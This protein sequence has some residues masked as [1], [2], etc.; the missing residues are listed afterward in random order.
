MATI[1]GRDN[2]RATTNFLMDD[3]TAEIQGNLFLTPNGEWDS[4]IVTVLHTGIDTIKQ[5]YKG[6]IKLD[7]FE[8]IESRYTDKFYTIEFNGYAGIEWAISSAQRGGYRYSLNNRDLGIVVMIGDIHTESKYEGHHL[9][10]ELSPWFILSKSIDVLQSCIDE[11]ASLFIHMF[12]HTGVAIHLCTDVQGWQVPNDLDSRLVTRAQRIQKYSGA[13]ELQYEKHSVATVYGKG[14]TFTFGGAGALQFSV[15]NKSKLIKK[16]QFIE[17]Y[18]HK[19]Y[20][21]KTKPILD[22]QSEFLEEFILFDKKKDVTRLEVRFHH[23]VIEQFARGLSVDL[24]SFKQVSEHLTGL[25]AYAFNNFRLD[26]S[27]TYIDPFWQFMRDDIVFNHDKNSIE[28]RR[29]YK[30]TDFDSPPSDRILKIIQGLL[31]SCYRRLKYDL[32]TAMQGL[33]KSGIWEQLVQLYQNRNDWDIDYTRESAYEDI[34]GDLEIKLFPP[35][36]LLP[37]C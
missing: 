25:W 6:Y 16:N 35:P 37:V 32:D 8:A 26:C 22:S 29:I 7:R 21:T 24:R 20:E 3:K 11:I 33:L 5:L 4:N 14:E 15:Y 13:M 31:T 28:Y 19:I 18:W 36:N 34:K 1:K 17:E 2:L 27:P 12:K 10:I 23:S 9:K 30:Q